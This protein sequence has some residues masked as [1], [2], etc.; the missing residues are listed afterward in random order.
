[1]AAKQADADAVPDLEESR[2][3]QMNLFAQPD[4]VA[5]ELKETLSEIDPNRI[6]PVEALMKLN[7]LKEMMQK[8]ES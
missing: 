1:V 6:T 2:A 5:E 7:E 3:G 8:G 4:P